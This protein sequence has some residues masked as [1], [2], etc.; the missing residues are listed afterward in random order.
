MP[1]LDLN[2]FYSNIFWL[3]IGF[4]SL[5]LISLRWILPPISKIFKIRKE[6]IN[7]NIDILNSNNKLNYIENEIITNFDHFNLNFDLITKRIRIQVLYFIKE[8][9]LTYE[10]LANT[11]LKQD[12]H[13]IGI[14]IQYIIN[15]LEK[16]FNISANDNTDI[17]IATIKYLNKSSLN[18]KKQIIN[19]VPI[20]VSK[21]EKNKYKELIINKKKLVKPI[22][23]TTS[24]EIK[25][26]HKPIIIKP[27]NVKKT[28]KN[29]IKKRN[30][31][32]KINN[33]NENNNLYNLDINYN[34]NNTAMK[35]KKT[36]T[37]RDINNNNN[38]KIK[39]NNN[40]KNIKN[41]INKDK[42][43]FKEKDIKNINN[44]KK[45]KKNIKKD[46]VTNIDKTVTKKNKKK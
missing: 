1:Q 28:N 14:L 15:K 37:K 8:E 21:K 32:N 40:N 26:K 33:I 35:I 46:N 20:H 4:T 19:A 45:E 25:E 3:L 23:L 18:L 11:E 41:N 24:T 22:I 2:T 7:N 30:K 13:D 6:L 29:K 10:N 43:L 42:K 12:W 9:V 27:N 5:Y 34:N 44:S 36:R 16:E 31:I 17:N 39:N 38:N